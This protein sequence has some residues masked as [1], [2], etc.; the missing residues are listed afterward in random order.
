[1]KYTVIICLKLKYKE[2]VLLALKIT[3]KVISEDY[4]I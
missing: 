1:M 4:W 2:I 3:M